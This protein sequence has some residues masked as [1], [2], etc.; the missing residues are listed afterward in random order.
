MARLPS[1][2]EKSR[3]HLA[4]P[5]HVRKRIEA[6][7]TMIE[8]ETITEVIRRSVTVYEALVTAQKSG[9]TIMLRARDGSEQIVLPL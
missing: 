5:L 1:T 4:L 7:R 3:L 8:A 2:D 6:L 9:S